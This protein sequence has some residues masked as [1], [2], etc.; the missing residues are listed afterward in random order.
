M[1]SILSI[2]L[3][4][5]LFG[6]CQNETKPIQ[7]GIK[8][9]DSTTVAPLKVY[10]RP[11]FLFTSTMDTMEILRSVVSFAYGTKVEKIDTTVTGD[12]QLLESE[13]MKQMKLPK[14]YI[15]AGKAFW[16]GLQVT[17]V[18]DSS[19]KGYT[20]LRQYQDEDGSGKEPFELVKFYPK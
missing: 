20:I 9:A 16:A 14:K 18:I 19:A 13:E 1:K 7:N 15:V 17:I 3:C 8:P 6:S 11:T 10:D 12:F 2:A 5:I 4:A